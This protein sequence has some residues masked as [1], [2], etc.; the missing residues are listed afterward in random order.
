MASESSDCTRTLREK[1]V[2]F[3]RIMTKGNSMVKLND[4]AREYAARLGMNDIV[5]DVIRFT[6]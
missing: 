5:L 2:V 3:A 1:E 6:S 4:A